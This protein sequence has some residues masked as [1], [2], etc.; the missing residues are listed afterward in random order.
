MSK[1]GSNMSDENINLKLQALSAKGASCLFHQNEPFL[2]AVYGSE[3]IE[4]SSSETLSNSRR[5]N[6]INTVLV[7]FFS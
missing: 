7:Y 3:T 4:S 2:F 6:V 5:R 1:V